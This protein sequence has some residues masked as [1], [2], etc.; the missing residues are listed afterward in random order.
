MAAASDAR[1]SACRPAA[2]GKD[3]PVSGGGFPNDGIAQGASAE[4]L[5]AFE[6]FFQNVKSGSGAAYVVIQPLSAEHNPSDLLVRFEVSDTGIGIRREEAL[7]IAPERL[8]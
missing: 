2:Q 6:Q 8:P 1:P 5:I 4:S 7:A 3:K